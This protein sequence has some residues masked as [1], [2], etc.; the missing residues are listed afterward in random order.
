MPDGKPAY[1]IEYDSRASSTDAAAPPLLSILK[2]YVLRSKVKLRDV[3]EEYDVWA[4]WGSE[5]KS[6]LERE[7]S[8]RKWNWAK[9]GA[10]EPDWSG[11]SQWPW[12]ME[13]QSIRDRRAV[14]M[15]RRMLVKKGERR[16]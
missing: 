6:E 9:S 16:E 15:G 5:D 7:I 8:E 4:A 13:K 12:G 1:L 10:V 11:E 2:K 3:S 14:G